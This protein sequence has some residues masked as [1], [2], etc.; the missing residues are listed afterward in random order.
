MLV[1]GGPK[2]ADEDLDDY[3]LDDDFAEGDDA[4]M[5]AEEDV[6]SP[7]FAA[8]AESALGT[9]DPDRVSAL[10]EAIRVLREEESFA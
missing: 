2:G 5:G 9:S 6:I 8:F 10:R 1:L 7:A 4:E 3:D